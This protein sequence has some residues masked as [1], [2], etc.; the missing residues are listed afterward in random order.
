[1][2]YSSDNPICS[3]N[4]SGLLT[5][6]S[7]RN[8][9]WSVFPS[10][11]TFMESSR[12]FVLLCPGFSRSRRKF[13]NF[14]ISFA[15]PIDVNVDKSPVALTP[16]SSR[17]TA[18]GNLSIETTCVLARSPA[19]NIEEPLR[20]IPVF[21]SGKSPFAVLRIVKNLFGTRNVNIPTGSMKFFISSV[22]AKVA[23]GAEVAVGAT[24]A[25]TSDVGSTF[26]STVGTK[27]AAGA[28]A[29]AT[30]D[31]DSVSAITKSS[32]KDLSAKLLKGRIDA[33]PTQKH[34]FILFVNHSLLVPPTF[35]MSFN[36]ST[37]FLTSRPRLYLPPDERLE[38]VFGNNLFL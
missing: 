32:A 18:I 17:S 30:S 21:S 28:T 15:F 3:N 1:M 5:S 24:A 33:L 25:T 31:A 2:R 19:V 26:A 12:I 16:A 38:L 34:L 4:K 6:I 29:A 11:E 20:P 22:G 10:L 27:V 7:A 37:S 14:A 36:T 8:W 35:A 9:N 23:V 13:S